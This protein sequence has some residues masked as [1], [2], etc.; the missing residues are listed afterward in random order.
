[1][2]ENKLD[3]VFKPSAIFFFKRLL[4]ILHFV[5]TRY[6]GKPM[7]DDSVNFIIE[8]VLVSLMNNFDFVWGFLLVFFLFGLM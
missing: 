6:L 3:A 2:A 5:V 8:L 4:C 1:M 7:T